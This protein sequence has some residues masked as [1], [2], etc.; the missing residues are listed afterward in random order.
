MDLEYNQVAK[1]KVFGIGG[2][3]CNAV[4]RMVED[5][6]QGVEFYVANTDIQDLNKSPVENK[7]IL[8]RETTRGLGAGAN[9]EIGRK[10]AMENEEEIREAM[11]GADMVF[12]T[13]GMGG[14]TGTGASP[15]FAKIA[16]EIGALT[17]G[18]VT[19]PFSFEGPR[20]N[21]QAEQGLAQLSEFI[22]SLIVVSNN[23]LL[24][25]IGR[26]PFVEAFKEADN[27]LRQGVQTITDLIAVPALINLDFADVRSV[28]EGQGS[29]LIGLGLSQSDH[30]AQA[31]AQK[32]IQCPLLEAQ[33]SGAKKAIVNVT[34]GAGI[35][36]FDGN[37]AAEYIREAAGNDI[38]IIFGVAINEKLGESIIVT[39]IATG[40]DLPKIKA[41]ASGK[42]SVKTASKMTESVSREREVAEE[43]SDINEIPDF[44]AHRGGNK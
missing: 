1:I 22:D 4:N 14:G 31:A 23:Q 6:V 42:P 5:G 2:A 8:G 40:F 24:Q 21:A 33:I 38:D 36:V 32:A 39:V 25:V 35:T 16:K 3:G 18:I 44:F 9:P 7:I 30:K 17:V 41:P 15:L 34:G 29:A 28:M 19:K 12:I 10:A 11:K 20:R 37:D 26:I 27:V 43:E 13:A